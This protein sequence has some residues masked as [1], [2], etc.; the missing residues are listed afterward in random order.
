MLPVAE[1]FSALSSGD[2]GRAEAI[3]LAWLSHVPLDDGAQLLLALALAASRRP[4]EALAHFEALAQ[5]QPEEPSHWSNLGNCLLELQRWEEARAALGH[6]AR[7]GGHPAEIG[8]ASA[9][10]LFGLGRFAEAEARLD[11]VLPAIGDDVDAVFL[12]VRLLLVRDEVESAGEW[13]SRWMNR[14]MSPAQ[15]N[16]AGDLLLQ[17]GWYRDALRCFEMAIGDPEVAVAARLGKASALERLNR[18]AEAEECLVSLASE[19]GVR[20]VSERLMQDDI[21]AQLAARRGR[22]REACELW[23]RAIA[24]GVEDSAERSDLELK[25]ARSLQALGDVDGCMA[26]AEQAHARKL[27]RT[28]EI[29]SGMPPGDRLLSL[30]DLPVASPLPRFALPSAESPPDPVFVVGFP[31]SGTTLLEQFLDAHPALQSFDEQPFLHRRIDEMARLGISFPEGLDRLDAGVVEALRSAYF[32]DI[33]RFVPGGEGL[34]AVDKNPLN[35]VRLPLVSAL[36]PGAKVVLALRHPCDVV[37]SCFLQNFRSP[38]FAVT[39]QSLESTAAMYARVMA[40]FERNRSALEVDLHINR[41]EDFVG[42]FDDRA[43]GLVDFL[44]LQWV[45]GLEDFTSRAAAKGHI[46]TPSYSQVVQP[47]NRAAIGRWEAFRP[48]FERGA[49]RHLGPWIEHWGY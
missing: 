41:Y 33:G 9:R 34:R 12:K 4:S 32:R 30:L 16:D 49:L 21:A 26:A 48:W 37:L 31:R 7:C 47:V 8:L 36:F 46:S 2:F 42:G 18:V 43:R 10:A 5:R 22:H 44:G 28:L 17:V 6:A 3:A 13:M 35:I 11:G 24:G 38:A 14:P 40:H 25:L 39:F 19:P 20:S 29:H 45:D 1:G 27:A 15:A 23:R